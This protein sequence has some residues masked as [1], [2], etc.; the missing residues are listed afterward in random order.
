[1]TS[2][3]LALLANTPGRR[4][5]EH[6]RSFERSRHPSWKNRTPFKEILV[7]DLSLDFGLTPEGRA[8]TE[9]DCG[10]HA[11]VTGEVHAECA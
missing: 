7:G 4:R 8:E 1:V 10:H 6:A 2:G 3:A 11:G 9:A 5:D